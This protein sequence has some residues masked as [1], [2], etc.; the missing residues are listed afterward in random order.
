[1]SIICLLGAEHTPLKSVMKIGQYR[2]TENRD[3]V[4]KN[5]I[6]EIKFY[7]KGTIGSL[8]DCFR[9]LKLFSNIFCTVFDIVQTTTGLF[10][11]IFFLRLVRPMFFNIHSLSV[12]MPELGGQSS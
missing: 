11:L 10:F 8:N 3:G 5:W 7:R 1:M 6:A 9:S 2:T 4:I 12:D